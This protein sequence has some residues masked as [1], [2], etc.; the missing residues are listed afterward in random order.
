MGVI[1]ASCTAASLNKSWFS[2]HQLQL[3]LLRHHQPSW[4][5]RPQKMPRQ[6]RPSISVIFGVILKKH[7]TKRQR[8]ATMHRRVATSCDASPKVHVPNS[9]VRLLGCP[10]GNRRKSRRE[11]QPM[12]N[13]HK[14]EQQEHEDQRRKM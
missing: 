2:L 7:A 1:L 10:A 4:L 14:I 8:S 6:P 13:L 5:P 11:R 9:G 12:K 3:W